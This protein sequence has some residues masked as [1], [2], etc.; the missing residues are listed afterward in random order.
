M[1][2]MQPLHRWSLAVL[3]MTGAGAIAPGRVVADDFPP[4]QPPSAGEYLLL[5]Q[6]ETAESR[7]RIQNLLPTSTDV[8]VCRYLDD[9]V[10]RAGGFTSLENANAWARYLTEVEGTQAF[11][12]RPAAPGETRPTAPIAAE[13]VAPPPPADPEPT[14]PEPEPTPSAAPS[15]PDPVVGYAPRLLGQG[16]A[17]LIDYD[18]QPAIAQQIQQT[19]NRPVGLA[20]YQQRPYLLASQTADAAAAA[21]VLQNLS[22]GR[23]RAFMVNSSDVVLLSPAVA[24]PNSP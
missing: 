23:F 11:V 24:I 18:N 2:W 5:V 20:V 8:M 9:T 4:C 10:V 22:S 12:A 21:Q 13:P 1:A 15:T 14:S 3:L 17:V 6:G 7:D 19:L 16:Y